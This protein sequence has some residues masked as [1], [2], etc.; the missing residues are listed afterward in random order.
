MLLKVLNQTDYAKKIGISRQ[1]L[2]KIIK[3]GRFVEGKD[4]LRISGTPMIILNSKTENYKIKKPG[5]QLIN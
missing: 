1:G 4:H 5:K 2:C 3:E